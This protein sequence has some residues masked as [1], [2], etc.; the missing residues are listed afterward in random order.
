MASQVIP[1]EIGVERLDQKAH[2]ELVVGRGKEGLP[3]TVTGKVELDRRSNSLIDGRSL[4]TVENHVLPQRSC[5]CGKST[6]TSGILSL[7]GSVY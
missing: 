7:V 6:R 5:A 4:Q 3:E 1:G 2:V